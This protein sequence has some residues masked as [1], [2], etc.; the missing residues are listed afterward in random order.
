MLH[1]Y[2]QL[3]PELVHCVQ[4]SGSFCTAHHVKQVPLH[5]REWVNLV[6][7]GSL[8][9]ILVSQLQTGLVHKQFYLQ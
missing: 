9:Y 1:L 6:K 7:S 3:H 2:Q 8:V 5:E 4:P